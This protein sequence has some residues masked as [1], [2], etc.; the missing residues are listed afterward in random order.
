M[1]LRV[2]G[3]GLGRT[4]TLSLKQA[5]ERLLGGP[6]YHMV[7]VFERPADFAVWT[8]AARGEPVDWRALF[9]GFAAVVDWPAASFWPE[10]AAA[11][12]DALILLSTRPAGAWWKSA[13]DTIFAS[14][15]RA[16]GSP[17]RAM[18][19]AIF[20]RR[21][22][23]AL[24]DRDAA[25]AAYE[26]HNAAVRAGAPAARL[27]AWTPADGWGPLCAALGVPVP[28]APFPHANTTA[29]FHA[30]ITQRRP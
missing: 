8:A 15:G 16:E 10:L 30:R 13:S 1:S 28:D 9:A 17:L 24:D 7:E 25:I 19:E 6:C 21:F 20:A 27:V 4:G 12:P 26:R 23:L 22:T 3:A 11:F 2:I 29:D 14:L 18:I 5:L